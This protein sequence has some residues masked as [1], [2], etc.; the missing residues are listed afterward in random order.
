M[1]DGV[2]DAVIETGWHAGHVNTADLHLDRRYQVPERFSL[3]AALNIAREWNWADFDPLECARYYDDG[4][5]YVTDG[6]HRVAAAIERNGGHCELP[7]NWRWATWD[8][9]ALMFARQHRNQRN[10]SALIEIHALTAGRE[11]EA[12]A[13]TETLAR[14]GWSF[15]LIGSNGP[16]KMA[17]GR[18]LRTIYRQPG[19]PE[20]LDWTLHV[21]TSAW[22]HGAS[23]AD[24]RV[25]SGL[26]LFHRLYGDRVN[27]RHLID[28]L[29]PELPLDVVGRQARE[30]ALK[31]NLPMGT[32][33]AD[34]RMSAEAIRVLYDKRLG[35]GRRL[36]PTTT[37]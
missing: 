6:Q 10:V 24:N 13:I 8:E 20:R 22:G 1:D 21:A 12:V 28:R 34:V 18:T 33:S 31:M 7:C 14:H 35:E 30:V 5:L 37:A 29:R 15:T 2:N 4:L 36:R 19:G 25:I 32:K 16:A 9:A 23:V 17:C 26:A 3:K 11:P 27:E